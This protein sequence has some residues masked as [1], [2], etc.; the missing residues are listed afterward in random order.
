MKLPYN[1]L[2]KNY[3]KPRIFLCETD[4]TKIGPLETFATQGTFKFNSYSEISFEIARVY[5]DLMTGE[6]KVNPLYDKVEA[7]RLIYVEGFGYFEIQGPEL[8][9]DGIKESKQ[10]TAYS[11]EYTLSQKYLEDFYTVNGRDEWAGSLEDLWQVKNN[12]YTTIPKIVLYNPDDKDASVLHLILE[13]IYGWTIGHIDKS[14]ETMSRAFDIDRMSVYDFI[15]TE[16]CEKFNCYAV[17]DTINNTINLYAESQTSKFIGDGLTTTFTISPP[18]SK[19]GVISVGGY[20]VSNLSYSYDEITGVLTFNEAP[21]E[22]EMIEVVD[23]AMEKWQTDVFVTFENLSQEINIS[24]D[25]ENIKTCLTV[26]YGDD[27]TIHEVNL[28]LP[29]LIDLSY[30]YSVDW[31]GEE[32]YEVYTEYLKTANN[33]QSDFTELSQLLTEWMNKKLYEENRMSLG[34]VIAD[35]VNEETR[36][37]YYIRSGIYPNCTYIEIYL[38]GS[39]YNAT[40][41]Y[42]MTQ[43][44]NLEDGSDGNV[45]ALYDALSEYVYYYYLAI[46]VGKND[47]LYDEYYAKR[48]EF[49]EEVAALDD[50]F[51]FMKDYGHNL[52]NLSENLKNKSIQNKGNLILEFLQDMWNEIGKTSLEQLYLPAYEQLQTNY[53]TDGW[54]KK[55]TENY[56][57][58]YITYIFVKSIK[59]AISE[60]EALIKEY[61]DEINI[62]NKQISNISGELIISNFFQNYFNKK[63]PDDQNKAKNSYEKALVRLSAFLREDELQLDDIVEVEIDTLTDVYATKRDAMEAGRIELQKLCQPQLQFSMSMANIYALREFDPIIDQFQLGKVIKVGLR[64]DYI[65][66]SRLLQVDI[67]FDD[68]SDFSC[69][70]GDLTSLRTQSDIHADLLKKAVSAGKQVAN[71]ASYWTQG[72]D[73][74]TKT[75]LKIQQGLLDA[76]TAIKSIDGLQNVF[77]DKYGIHLQKKDGTTGEIDQKQAWFVNNS[78]MF[79]DDGWESSKAGLG[80]FTVDGET[81]YGLIAEA[82]IAGYIEGSKIVG[83]TINIGDGAFVVHENGSVTM[84]GG[85]GVSYD[86]DGYVKDEDLNNVKNEVNKIQQNV[87]NLTASKMYRIEI[88]TE[89]STIITTAEEVSRLICKVYSW[90]EDITDEVDAQFFNWKRISSNTEADEVWNARPEHQSKKSIEIIAADVIE[91]SNFYCEV[92]LPGQ[93]EEE[94]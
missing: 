35:S 47:P 29:Y 30:Y 3:V 84:N 38:D 80:E 87:G 16:I 27:G 59:D 50:R 89:G 70:F 25:A 85:D 17:F 15:M 74:A 66:Q 56:G 54:S 19:I 26:T 11:L 48:G 9:S 62:I 93:Q 45:M 91:N 39:N 24:Y 90:D 41:T 79:T 57:R 6:T 83:G 49:L 55:E 65:K 40:E 58:Y 72:S 94:V 63:Y 31:M 52:K 33:R 18:F 37:T 8:Y 86:I 82:V 13:K 44:C 71:N 22:N 10:V 1:I 92:E 2:T 7:L 69:E 64:P 21:E 12:D 28:G 51:K 14:L 81:F 75:D 61:Q 42:Y 77:I 78:L 34:Y 5:N 36:G 23:G 76:T 20:K 68:L 32:L 67:N 53:V 4:K 88:I 46:L 73:A 60:R 43:G